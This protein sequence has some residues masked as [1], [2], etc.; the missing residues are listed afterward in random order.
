MIFPIQYYNSPHPCQGVY[1]IID[2]I[3]SQC[4]WRLPLDERDTLVNVGWRQAGKKIRAEKSLHVRRVVEN[5]IEI[6]KKQE[7]ARLWEPSPG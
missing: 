4:F 3:Y 6:G 5:G 2:P 1:Q 7:E